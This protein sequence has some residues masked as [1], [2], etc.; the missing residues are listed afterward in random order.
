MS[1]KDNN[2]KTAEQNKSAEIAKNVAQD[3]S[4]DTGA[5]DS[6]K[7]SKDGN[8]SGDHS[9]GTQREANAKDN[10][11]KGLVKP[12]DAQRAID[13]SIPSAESDKAGVGVK[14]HP[15]VKTPD[16]HA[17]EGTMTPAQMEKEAAKI[18]E[19]ADKLKKAEG[20]ARLDAATEQTAKLTQGQEGPAHFAEI[21]RQVRTGEKEPGAKDDG[22]QKTFAE[23]HAA[24]P[25]E[26]RAEV[27]VNPLEYTNASK[28]PSQL[29][30]GEIKAGPVHGSTAAAGL[31]V[32]QSTGIIETPAAEGMATHVPTRVQAAYNLANNT[33]A[34]MISSTGSVATA[35]GSLATD[36]PGAP[37][38]I[39]A[40]EKKEETGI[41][42]IEAVDKSIKDVPAAYA[43][44]IQRLASYA[45]DMAPR[46][47]LTAEAGARHQVALY[48]A[49][50]AII[51]RSPDEYFD[52]LFT[53]VLKF[54]E[55][56][57]DD[58]FHETNV[59]RFMDSVQLSKDEMQGF[60]RLLNLIKVLGPTKGRAAAIKQIDFGNSLR[61]G[62]TETGRQRILRYFKV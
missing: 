14:T 6:S 22:T 39:V 49:L 2:T 34:P 18:G 42:G 45:N 33:T 60:Q 54:S 44:P 27:G 62:L 24:S 55:A 12:G 29:Q 19:A 37:D 21:A 50:Q 7:D 26:R 56:H 43:A 5:K 23:L 46:R 20:Q 32:D 16:A 30:S 8:K 25:N 35:G 9:T 1:N 58:V 51:N 11:A 47:P 4:K 48:R 15:D 17:R 41:T 31:H 57:Q 40:A 36:V 53:A 3:T 13:P 61:Y 59:F 10:Q 28:D 52:Q 38:P